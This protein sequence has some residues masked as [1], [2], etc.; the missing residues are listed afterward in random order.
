MKYFTTQLIALIII[1]ISFFACSELRD[2]LTQPESAGVHGNGVLNTSSQNFHGKLLTTKTFNDCQQCHATDFSGGTAGVNCAT[3]HPSITYHSVD[4]QSPI[5][6]HPQFLTG[7][8]WDMDGCKTCHGTNYAGGVS[9]PSCLTCHTESNGPEACNTCH[10]D[11]SDASQI[12][13]PRAINGATETTDPGVGAHVIHLTGEDISSKV[14]CENCHVVPSSL[15]DESHLDAEAPVEGETHADVIFHG[16]AVSSV[17]NSSYNHETYKC[18]NTYCHGN[19]ELEKSASDY[20]WAY[21]SDKIAGNNFSPTWNK[22]D[23][24]QAEC[25]TCHGLPP[26]GHIEATMTECANC[27]PG[28]MNDQ[29]ELINKSLHINGEPNVFNN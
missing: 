12:N 4:Y 10:G 26:T 9:T 29:G 7:I 27:H 28:V 2:N 22:V 3:C 23:G 18:S 16:V 5:G 14:V 6:S 21:T 17:S 19:F 11:F 24:T 25:G 1:G 8:N 15:N 20:P 13:P